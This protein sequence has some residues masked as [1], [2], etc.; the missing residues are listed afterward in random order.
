MVRS[1]RRRYSRSRK[2]ALRLSMMHIYAAKCYFT[3][4]DAT[5]THAQAPRIPFLDFIY[6]HRSSL[7]FSRLTS[8]TKRRH[9]IPPSCHERN[10][11]I[12]YIYLIYAIVK[13][14]CSSDEDTT[15]CPRA[16]ICR[17]LR[18][19]AEL[20]S[21]LHMSALPA[22]REISVSRLRH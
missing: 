13:L 14:R 15:A 20:L 3:I 11:N 9:R 16:S 1:D 17:S 18:F 4:P 8:T 2:A 19:A 22:G 10:L 5:F 21:T 7:I 12:A 6:R